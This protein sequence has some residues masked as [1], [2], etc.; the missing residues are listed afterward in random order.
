MI[1]AMGAPFLTFL[2]PVYSW[3]VA[4][5]AL[6][7]A[8]ILSFAGPFLRNPGQQTRISRGVYAGGINREPVRINTLL[9]VLLLLAAC[10]AVDVA[11]ALVAKRAFPMHAATIA[12]IAMAVT[13]V[14]LT[15]ALFWLQEHR[16]SEPAPA[17]HEDPEGYASSEGIRS[18]ILQTI[19]VCVYAALLLGVMMLPVSPLL[20]RALLRAEAVVIPVYLVGLRR[21]KMGVYRTG[22][23]GDY[24][25]ALRRDRL[26]SAMPFY[27]ASLRGMI[28]FN[29]G[30][31]REAQAFLKPLAFDAQGRP[32]LASLE[33]YSYALALVNDNRPGEAEPLLEAA[34]PAVPRNDYLKVALASCLL[35]QEKDPERA[36]RLLEEAMASPQR[37]GQ[38]SNNRADYARRIA[39]YAWALSA[40]GRR[41]EAQSRIDEA[42]QLALSLRPEDAAGVQYF[43]GEAWRVMGDGAKAQAAYDEA[44]RLQPTG[45]IALSVKKAQAKMENRWHAWQPQ[46]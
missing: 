13:T 1:A 7:M 16:D 24:D 38:A 41:Q 30:R 25:K 10:L 12:R 23:K 31:Y 32:R 26:W 46:T 39:R 8:A 43:V 18:K 27:G 11:V 42:Q 4:I 33:L 17:A 5:A 2:F 40:C 3:E 22:H 19:F 45:V 6:L 37:G 9:L 28:L 29:A 44:V 20:K 35:T 21:I 14:L 36:T 34:I 15:G